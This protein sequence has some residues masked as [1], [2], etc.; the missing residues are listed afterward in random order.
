MTIPNEEDL[1][2]NK[3]LEAADKKSSDGEELDF[4]R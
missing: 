3:G 2:L 4:E 1:L